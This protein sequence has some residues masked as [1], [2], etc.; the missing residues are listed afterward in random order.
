MVPETKMGKVISFSTST[1]SGCIEVGRKRYDFPST[2]FLA[3][4]S[5]RFP[6]PGERVEVILKPT[7]AGCTV[8]AVCASDDD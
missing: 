5:P 7:E 1:S 3:V 4:R 8:L 6:K 2:S